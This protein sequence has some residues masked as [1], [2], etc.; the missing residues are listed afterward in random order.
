VPLP[1]PGTTKAVGGEL[2]VVVNPERE[3]LL[4]AQVAGCALA[5]I[6][7]TNVKDNNKAGNFMNIEK[8]S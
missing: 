6:E 1:P 3:T 2:L 4:N 7:N 5:A 8:V